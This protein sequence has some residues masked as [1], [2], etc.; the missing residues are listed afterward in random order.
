VDSRVSWVVVQR[1]HSG[2]GNSLF[3]TG[4]A[5]EA[6]K[7]ETGS[8]RFEGDLSDR[9]RW[10]RA[11]IGDSENLRFSPK[12]TVSHSHLN[13]TFMCKF[14]RIHDLRMHMDS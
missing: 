12:F 2:A 13:V 1:G 6:Q 4:W 9:S 5:R 11:R 8:I 14:R 7:R 3:L 10:S